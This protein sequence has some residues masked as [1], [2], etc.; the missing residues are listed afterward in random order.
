MLYYA[1]QCFHFRVVNLDG[2]AGLSSEYEVLPAQEVGKTLDHTQRNC[3][4]GMETLMSN[5]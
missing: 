1:R 2:D 4:T 3:I 5:G